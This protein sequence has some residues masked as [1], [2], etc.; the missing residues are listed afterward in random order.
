MPTAATNLSYVFDPKNPVP[1]IGGN[2]L[3]TGCGPQ[4]Q[5][6]LDNRSDILFFLTEP[7]KQT[8]AILGE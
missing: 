1:T 2:N 6:P 3:F 7:F 5:S 4:D 8:T